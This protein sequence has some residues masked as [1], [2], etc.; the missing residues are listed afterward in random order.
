MI[1]TKRIKTNTLAVCYTYDIER[2]G[3]IPG[4]SEKRDKTILLFKGTV[5]RRL[6][7]QNHQLKRRSDPNIVIFDDSLANEFLRIHVACVGF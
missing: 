1:R 4:G 2:K 7:Y 3:E 6:V 5:A